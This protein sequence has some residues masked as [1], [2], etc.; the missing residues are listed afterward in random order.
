MKNNSLLLLVVCWLWFSNGYS[1]DGKILTRAEKSDFKATT[2]YSEVID[3]LYA[4]QKQ[5]HYIRISSIAQSV[6]GRDVPLA[7]LGN[8]LPA[9]ASDLLITNKPAIYIQANIHAGEVEGKEASLMLMREILSGDLFHLLDNQVLLFTP[10]FNPDGNEKIDPRNRRNQLGP[11]SGVG[12]RYNGQNLDLNR[13]YMK[14]ESPENIGALQL[15]NDWDPLLLIDLHTTNGS[16]HQEPLTYATSHN[17]NGDPALPQY[18]REKLFPE[19]AQ[20]LLSQHKILSLP[21]GFFKD[22]TDPEKGWRSFNHQP[23]YSTNYWGLRNRFS[24]LNENYAYADYQTRIMVCYHFVE[25]ILNYT[26]NHVDEMRDM[27]RK[28]DQSSVA[29]GMSPDTSKM[30]GLEFEAVP[31]EK[32]LLVR[33][34]EFDLYQDEQGR[35]RARKTDRL[36]NYQTP[37]FSDFRMTR[38]I[39]VPKGYFF[40]AN[41]KEIAQKLIQHGIVVERLS[42]PLRLNLQTFQIKKVDHSERMYQ[43]HRFTTLSGEYQF[44]ELELERGTFF[45]GMNQPL[46][47]LVAYLL[48]PESDGGLVYWNFFDRYLHASQWG[49]GYNVFPVFRLMQPEKFARI[50]ANLN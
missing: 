3:F 45:V 11:D 50:K 15:I 23:Y 10:I 14:L 6:E 44:Q 13:D 18:V 7:V 47:N 17:P 40:P 20:Q 39:V 4:L 8:P 38:S 5:S 22:A 46:A 21:Y 1:W 36:K 28:A 27:V 48:E 25:Q 12:I 34:Y 35:K 9:S 26:N 49:G 37:F 19:V 24:I 16:Y 2:R 32:P 41:L 43:G 30:F 29:Y 42:Q 33:S 31:F